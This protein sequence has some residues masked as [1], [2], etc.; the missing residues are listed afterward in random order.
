MKPREE[1]SNG[2]SDA[3]LFN[4]LLKKKKLYPDNFMKMKLG[5]ESSYS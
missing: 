2:R 3:A 1:E 4:F 5:V